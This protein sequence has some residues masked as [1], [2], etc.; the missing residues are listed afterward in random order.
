MIHV[1]VFD[2]AISLG[3]LS[4]ERDEGGRPVVL[5]V[6][7]YVGKKMNFRVF[8]RLSLFGESPG[9]VVAFEHDLH[10]GERKSG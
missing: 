1:I 9:T 8:L 10:E 3:P 5:T 6:M 2:I 4:G 7:R